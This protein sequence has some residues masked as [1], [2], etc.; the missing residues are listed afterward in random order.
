M[1]NGNH[2][3][4]RRTAHI[5]GWLCMGWLICSP[6]LSAQ[7][8]MT[9]DDALKHYFPGASIERRT[10]FLTAEQVEAIQTRANARVESRVLTYYV[11]HDDTSIVGTAFFETQTV[12]TMPAT[13]VT[14]INPDTTLRLVEILGFF[15][16]EDYLPPRGW[17][18]QFNG[19]QP[20]DDLYLKR[21][22][23]NIAGATM[24]AQTLTDGIRRLRATYEIVVAQ[25]VDSQ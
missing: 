4:N 23:R 11:A 10:A 3:M 22:I 14:V 5:I 15:E 2:T 17:L 12:R 8:R 16:P 20:D 13:Y 24:T 25:K 7:I 6:V 9:K 1:A 21:G 19:V 18:A